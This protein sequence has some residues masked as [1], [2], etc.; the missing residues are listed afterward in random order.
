MS[1][2]SPGTF[3]RAY[4]RRKR[5]VRVSHRHRAVEG[6][7]RGRRRLNVEE[8]IWLARGFRWTLGSP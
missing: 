2:A 1:Y 4:L 8:E 3:F 5:V 6:K 7:N